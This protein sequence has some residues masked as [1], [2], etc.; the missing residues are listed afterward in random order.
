MACGTAARVPF[1]PSTLFARTFS[2]RWRVCYPLLSA[3]RIRD[4]FRPSSPPRHERKKMF[5][6]AMHREKIT[7]GVPGKQNGDDMSD[8]STA[9][10]DARQHGRRTDPAALARCAFAARWRVVYARRRQRPYAR[11]EMPAAP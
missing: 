6:A 7:T 5:S 8:S 4:V 9:I 11:Q 10:S 3:M 1:L 2:A